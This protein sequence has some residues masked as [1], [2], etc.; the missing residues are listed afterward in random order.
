[1]LFDGCVAAGPEACPFH[2]SSSTEI[3]ANFNSLLE[4]IRAN[5]VDVQ[6]GNDNITLTYGRL[7]QAT[8]NALYQVNNYQLFAT[9][10]KEL[11]DGNGT[12]LAGAVYV[13]YRFLTRLLTDNGI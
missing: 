6:I 12:I 5:P 9:G 7:R 2:A 11:S 3:N 8:F 10:L 13:S 4:S 1:M